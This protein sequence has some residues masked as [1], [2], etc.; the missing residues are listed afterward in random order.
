M[1]YRFIIAT[2]IAWP[3]KRLWNKGICP[4]WVKS[5]PLLQQEETQ[6][7]LLIE[8]PTLQPTPNDIDY[9][10]LNDDQDLD[11]RRR[12]ANH[13]M[14]AERKMEYT[15]WSPAKVKTTWITPKPSSSYSI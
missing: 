14:A 15:T 3:R 12:F 13:I 9:K 11:Q 6:E 5:S 8:C 2:Q 10:N 1:Q 4:Q 7:H